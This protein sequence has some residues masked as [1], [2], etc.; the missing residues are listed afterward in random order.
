MFTPVIEENIVELFGHNNTASPRGA[1]R[2][3]ALPEQENPTPV[4]LS[5][6]TAWRTWLL[7]YTE[8]PHVLYKRRWRTW[9][10]P[11]TEYPHVLYKRRWRTWL[12]PYTEYPHTC[13]LQT[14]LA[15]LE[16]TAA[17]SYLTTNGRRRTVYLSRYCS[18]RSAPH[19]A[20][21]TADTH[22]MPL[23][24]PCSYP[25]IVATVPHMGIKLTP[26]P[27]RLACMELLSIRLYSTNAPWR[28][29]N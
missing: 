15:Y 16:A 8:Y 7:P 21:Y 22:T 2:K 3:N 6:D 18:R 28:I 29:Y 9:L 24:I 26:I 19:T 20:G 10:L 13:T 12:L 23:G 27:C 11:Y 17:C 14:P 5:A 4:A 25:A 1:T